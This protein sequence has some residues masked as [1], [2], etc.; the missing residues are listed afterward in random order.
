MLPHASRTRKESATSTATS[1]SASATNAA[2]SRDRAK[3][4]TFSTTTA[5][6]M[7][8]SFPAITRADLR[9]S[10]GAYE[11]LISATAAYRGALATLAHASASLARTLETCSRL[12]GISDD[13]ALGFQAAGGLHHVIANHEQ[14]LGRTMH[15]HVEKPLRQHLETYKSAVT[16]RSSAYEKTLIDRSK[17][18]RQT[19]RESLMTGRRR[20]RDL[21]SFRQALS[22]LQ[23]QVDDLDRLKAD[24]YEEV[25]MHEENVWDAVL[26]KVAY[27]VRSTLDVYDRITSKASDPQLEPLILSIPDPFDTYTVPGK[28]DGQGGS[29]QPQIFSILPPLSMSL[30][31]SSSPSHAGSPRASGATSPTKSTRTA[32]TAKQRHSSNGNGQ[33]ITSGSSAVPFPISSSPSAAG[34]VVASHDG[35]ALNSY[36]TEWASVSSPSSSRG[37]SLASTT[38]HATYSS[39]QQN[40]PNNNSTA[41]NKL[42]NMLIRSPSSITERTEIDEGDMTRSRISSRPRQNGTGRTG[43]DDDNVDSD[44]DTEIGSRRGLRVEGSGGTITQRTRPSMRREDSGSTTKGSVSAPEN[45]LTGA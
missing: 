11:D 3:S 33:G 10:I 19:E 26:G 4:P 38:A 2:R 5:A 43:S 44:T 31:T 8:F 28:A 22:V 45:G 15:D 32:T 27:S 23:A 29:A 7:P 16:E 40:L 14:V 21:A 25:L 37:P 20:Q 36:A 6:S 13:A 17:V 35:S 12:K 42:R 30:L 24:Y 1:T 34:L 18:I 39:H 9:Q 41:E